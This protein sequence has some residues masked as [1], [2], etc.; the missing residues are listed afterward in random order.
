MLT[1]SAA[2]VQAE[3]EIGEGTLTLAKFSAG[4]KPPV[5][6]LLEKPMPLKV[7][8]YKISV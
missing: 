5:K 1:L 2:A 3:F 8:L 4:N 6:D 7:K